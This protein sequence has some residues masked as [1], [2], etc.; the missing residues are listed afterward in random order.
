[1][2]SLCDGRLFT[3]MICLLCVQFIYFF[4]SFCRAH[5]VLDLAGLMCHR[6]VLLLLLYIP[7]YHWRESII[8]LY[9]IITIEADWWCRVKALT[10]KRQVKHNQTWS[11]HGWVTVCARLCA[12]PLIYSESSILSMCRLYKS[13]SYEAISS[14]RSPVHMC[15]HKSQMFMLKIL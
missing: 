1:M 7:L 11:L 3:H 8:I 2:V 9:T 4:A 12:S 6:N 10:L 5:C 15:T 13:P 14:Q